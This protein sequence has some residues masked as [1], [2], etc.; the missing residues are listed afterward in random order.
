M[1][2]T[3]LSIHY[4]DGVLYY[5]HIRKKYKSEATKNSIETAIT[6]KE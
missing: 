1:F 3:T 6:Y 2:A 4:F 5:S